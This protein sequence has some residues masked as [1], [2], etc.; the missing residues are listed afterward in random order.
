[1]TR[2][3]KT[4]NKM[5]QLFFSFK[6]VFLGMREKREKKKKTSIAAQLNLLL[7]DRPH[8]QKEIDAPLSTLRQEQDFGHHMVPHAPLEWHE[9]HDTLRCETHA[10][11]TFLNNI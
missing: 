11:L 3:N 9:G 1:M 5:T 6:C 4:T 2:I 10:L 8:R 7:E